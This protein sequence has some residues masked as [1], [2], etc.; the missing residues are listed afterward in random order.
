[1]QE[2]VVAI[3]DGEMGGAPYKVTK[4]M[5][6]AKIQKKMQEQKQ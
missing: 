3:G 4:E 1:M 5:V 6:D 2:V